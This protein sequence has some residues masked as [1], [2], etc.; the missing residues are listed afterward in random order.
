MHLCQ[1]TRP[2]TKFGTLSIN[3]R[4]RI[5]P[6]KD[7]ISGN[8]RAKLNPPDKTPYCVYSAILWDKTEL[9][10]RFQDFFKVKKT[11]LNSNIYKTWQPRQES[12][13]D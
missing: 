6:E 1:T 3:Q 8:Q 2:V 11:I 4:R 12:N 9:L 5:N 13:L 7:T 10:G